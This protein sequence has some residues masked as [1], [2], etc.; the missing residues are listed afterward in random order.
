MVELHFGR[1]NSIDVLKNTAKVLLPELDNKIT[2][3]LPILTEA[4]KEDKEFFTYR[5][6]TQVACLLIGNKGS[7]VK[8]GVIL[9]TWFT[10]LIP[11]PSGTAVEKRI[12]EYPGG[13]IELN[14][15]T[16]NLS[17]NLVEKIT[18]TVPEIEIN[19]HVTINGDIDQTGG[20]N[21]TKTI[22]SNEDV[23]TK[24]VSLLEHPHSYT[25]DGSPKTTGAPIPSG[26]IK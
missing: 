14:K 18:I 24:G 5:E 9:G 12:W 7:G 20:I 11:C 3:P 23:T 17:I 1:I 19:A 22:N 16:G 10:D 4:S 15:N 6:G 26:G 25:D 2:N 21:S 13:R 8:R